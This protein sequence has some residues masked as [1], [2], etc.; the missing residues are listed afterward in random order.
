MTVAAIVAF[1]IVLL[2]RPLG[3]WRANLWLKGL[4]GNK[5]SRLPNC[6]DDPTLQPGSN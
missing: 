5:E 4:E 6:E 3:R 1:I 2:A